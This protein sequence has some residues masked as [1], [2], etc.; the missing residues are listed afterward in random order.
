MR[1]KTP[2]T[3]E[4]LRTHFTYGLWKYVLL[5]VIAIAGWS[6]M[7]TVTA[8]HSP[9]NKRIDLYVQTATTSSEV[10]D[11]FIEP[12]WKETV[13]EM[14]TVSSVVL[15]PSDDST[16]TMQLFTYITVGE[17]D[18]YFLTE[19]FFK[20]FASQG[21]F[22]ELD[23]LVKTGMIDVGDVDLSKGYVAVIDAY[24]GDQAVPS[25]TRHLYGIPLESF[26]GY[27]NNILLDNRNLYAVILVNNQ[28][29]ENVI[30]FFNALLQAG[31]GEKAE[32]ITEMENGQGR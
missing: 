1:L 9:Q 11:E 29:D 14:E 2:V 19:R 17:G 10:I 8:Y 4:N 3:S 7:Y 5:A 6:I 13:P 27:M 21:A 15:S 28:N 25:S 18:I 22:L 32:W 20:D 24:E 31:R 23:E 12:I 16:T 26:Y 30:P